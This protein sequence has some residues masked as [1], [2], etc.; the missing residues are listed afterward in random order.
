MLYVALVVSV[1]LL[2]FARLFVLCRRMEWRNDLVSDTMSSIFHNNPALFG[3]PTACGDWAEADGCTR[4]DAIATGKTQTDPYVFQGCV[5]PKEI[6][7]EN[8]IVF[9]PTKDDWYKDVESCI[10]DLAGAK[11]MT[12]TSESDLVSKV[13]HVTVNSFFFGFMDDMYI[14]FYRN[15]TSANTFIVNM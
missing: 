2:G 1:G 9:S 15:T 13:I 14:L 3:F 10:N 7:D 11:I 8:T 4:I 6:P 12:G 5:R